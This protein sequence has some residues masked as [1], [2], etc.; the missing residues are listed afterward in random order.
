MVINFKNW[1]LEHAESYPDCIDIVRLLVKPKRDHVKEKDAREGWWRFTRPRP[2]LYRA[3]EELDH[4]LALAQVSN[5]LAVAR[6]A[7]GQVFDQQCVIFALNSPA[8]LATLSSS[9]HLI[10]TMR[11][12]ATKRTDLSYSPS[13]I[14]ATFPRPKSTSELIELGAGLDASRRTLMLSQSWGL[15]ATYNHVNDPDCH[16]AAVTNLRDLHVAIDEAVLMAYGW[17]DLDLKIG[18]HPTKIGIRWTVSKEARFELL[19]RLLEENQRRYRAE[20]P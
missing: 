1:P 14:F 18:H 19:D 5:T 8:D 16:D 17:G 12:T 2:E 10:W 4:V 9:S 20:N 7:T 3:I 6:V 15:T 11:Y 13:D